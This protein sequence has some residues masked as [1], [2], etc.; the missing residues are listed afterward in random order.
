MGTIG[1][2]VPAMN[3]P[4]TAT[5]PVLR[6]SDRR[7]QQ[8][9]EAILDQADIRINGS[10]PW[11]IQVLNDRFY[12]RV[13]AEGALGLG[14]AYMEGW[15][16]AEA[17]DEFFFRL[18][19]IDLSQVQMPLRRKLTY[20]KDRLINRQSTRRAFTVGREHYDRG[21]DLFQVMLDRRMTYTCAYWKNAATLDE[22]QEAKLELTCRKLRLRPG[23]TV[24]DI[25]CG[26][27]S[28]LKYA[29]ENYGVSGVGVTVSKE[30]V[31]L[32]RQMCAG[33]PVEIRLQDYRDV[34]GRFDHVV[35]LGM[36]E[37]VG[38]NNYRRFFEVARNC[39]ADSGLLLLHTIGN[40]YSDTTT[41]PWTEKY[42]FPNSV[43]PSVKQIGEASERLFIVEDWHN[44]G[45]H[46]DPTLMA[47]WENF[48]AGWET[49]EPRYG[50]VFY[51][52]WKF[53][54]LS[55]AGAFRSRKQHLWQIVMS[56]KGLVGGYEAV[57]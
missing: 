22:A 49:L 21:N 13:L 39:L 48:D 29:A 25:G 40:R 35:S 45:A 12:R 5:Q 43:I 31:E 30:Q 52:M 33:L 23:Q 38:P 10:Q 46:Y 36:F 6:A 19:R 8:F 20:A 47:W 17:L 41:D 18:L 2:T 9:V 51:R 53:F 3:T 32:G 14:E 37:H 34:T 16:E 28:F 56:K 55:A 26:W 50:D 42:I 15:W 1:Q 24:L 27:G 54:L 44:F 11:D 7:R 4:T 57:R